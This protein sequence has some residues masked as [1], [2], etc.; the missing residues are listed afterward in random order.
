MPWHIEKRDDEYCVVK[1]ADGSSAGCHPTEEEA[2]AQLRALYASENRAE[3]EHRAPI[4]TRSATVG[5][6]NFPQRIIE[7]IAVPYE[8]E[9][10]IEYRGEMWRESFDRGSFAGVEQRRDQIKA[11]RDHDP[12]PTGSAS[13]S[14]LVGRVI[15]LDP[16][17]P[18]GLA[19][20]VK[21]A[22]TDLG[23]DTLSLADE[24]ILGVSVGFAVRG[25]DQILDRIERRR[26]I[27]RAFL[28]HLAFPDNGAYAGA[29]IVGVRSG[30]RRMASDLPKLETPL[31]DDVVAWLESRRQAP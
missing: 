1:D 13:K 25:R 21:I 28:D 4:E 22:K 7:V 17:R 2:K 6:V 31:L 23:D 30:E 26:R 12:N 27:V 18:E 24:R 3:L 11:Y 15:H 8:Q 10:T 5:E 16:D 29:G 9:A 20:A 14:G 19:G